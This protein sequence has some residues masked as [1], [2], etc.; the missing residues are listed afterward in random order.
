MVKAKF[1]VSGAEHSP[2]QDPEHM[3]GTVK[4][5]A[6]CRGAVNSEWAA[7]TP[8]GSVTMY[9]NNPSA[10]RWFHD[11]LGKEVAISFVEAESD[12]ATHPF[13]KSD[14][15]DGQYGATDCADCGHPESAHQQA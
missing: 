9:V 12:P 5:S 11:R 8:S 3:Q 15:P 6:V 1:F 13:R 2:G 14:V 4:L 10:F 7:A